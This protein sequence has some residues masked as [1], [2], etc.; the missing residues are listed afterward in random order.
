MLPARG[1]HLLSGGLADAGFV[2]Q[3]RQAV[4]RLHGDACA[5]R[6]TAAVLWGFDMLHEPDVVELDV[7]H[8]HR[9]PLMDG[10]VFRQARGSGTA[11]VVPVAGCRALPATSAV[12]TVLDCA[13]ELPLREAVAIADSALRRGACTRAQLRHAVSARRGQPF[14]GRLW[15]VVLWCDPRCGSLLESLLRVLLCEADLRP[16]RAQ[17]RI[18]DGRVLVGRVDFAWPEQLLVVEADGRRWHDP[19]DARDADRRRDNGCA[20]LGWRVLRFTWAEVVHEPQ[21]VVAELRAALSA[22]VGTPVAG[23]RRVHDRTA[24]TGGTTEAPA[25]T[26]VRGWT[27]PVPAAREPAALDPSTS[28]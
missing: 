11:L 21:R 17:H 14:N 19:A 16:P 20:R 27:D 24:G 4:L 8:G 15:R 9:P 2:A 5:A 13:A 28:T 12:D 26:G 6:R 23:S 10:V 22:P 3:V 25:V 7:P 1:E 18:V